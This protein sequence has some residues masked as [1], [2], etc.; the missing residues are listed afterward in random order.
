MSIV[1]ISFTCC[2]LQIYDDF[3]G[4]FFNDI[5]GGILNDYLHVKG[6]EDEQWKPILDVVVATIE[7]TRKSFKR[8]TDA[9]K[10]KPKT[11]A[12]CQC[13]LC[14]RRKAD[15]T[16]SHMVPHFLIADVFTYDGSRSRDKVVVE[17]DNLSIGTKEHYF[18]R[19]VYDDTVTE[20]LGR[21]LTDEELE[22]E[23]EKT[24]ALT[25]DYIFCSDCEKRFGVIESYYSEILNGKIKDYPPQIPYLFWMSVVWRMDV[26]NMGAELAPEH[27]EKLRKI[28][29]KCLALT[30][31][32]IVVKNS[33]LGHCAYSLYHAKDTRDEK[34]SIVGLHTPSKPYVALMGRYHIRF[35][36]SAYSAVSFCKHNGMP[37]DELNFGT[38]P[39]KITEIPFIEFWKVKRFLLDE[40]WAHD[41]SILHLGEE[42]NQTISKFSLDDSGF[43]EV[44][45]HDMQ[46]MTDPDSPW[47]HQ[48]VSEN[49]LAVMY[50]HSIL[51]IMA[52]MKR[53]PGAGHEAISAE[54]GYSK[55]EL[56]VM[57][58]YMYN[59]LSDKLAMMD[60]NAI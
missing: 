13:A 3:Y 10:Q 34:L 24:N 35:Y 33:K 18:G 30:R 43:R 26:G 54:T 12:S 42:N 45:G 16:G 46:E 2:F 51:K 40:T 48:M 6:W 19:E 29:D 5:S 22:E 50:P 56:E 41:R 28:L 53:N 58:G 14:R 44:F 11:D 7:R 39:E 27:L 59:K 17:A 52:A 9:E 25:R 49:P 57:M 1:I 32:D 20:L 15:K 21:S 38:S 4:P 31:E 47:M 23:A 60:D 36:M 55:E 37:E 8:F